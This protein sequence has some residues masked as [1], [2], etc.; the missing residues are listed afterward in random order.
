M[1]FDATISSQCSSGSGLYVGSECA[2]PVSLAAGR[3]KSE[4]AALW[5]VLAAK[6]EI[7]EFWVS[8]AKECSGPVVISVGRE[9][10][11]PSSTLAASNIVIS[12]AILA[13]SEIDAVH[14]VG[15]FAGSDITASWSVLTAN[16]SSSRQSVGVANDFNALQGVCVG[17]EAVAPH[18]LGSFAKAETKVVFDL[19]VA[20]E[21]I[22]SWAASA[23]GEMESH[24]G[25]RVAGDG[26]S[27]WAVTDAATI[28]SECESP[29]VIHVGQEAV[30]P[31]VLSG[32]PWSQCRALFGMEMAAEV[33]A[34]FGIRVHE[35]AWSSHI[36]RSTSEMS[37]PFA[38]TV[39]G[40]CRSLWS[41]RSYLAKAAVAPYAFSV[42]V[43]GECNVPFDLLAFNPVASHMSAIWCLLP[44]P[45]SEVGLWD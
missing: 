9:M 14:S 12:E 37:S 5:G 45:R 28:A 7:S 39:V 15:R 26:V 3:V 13:A 18:S 33:G 23:A 36:I 31:Y 11:A 38:C 42:P 30:V 17:S 40:Q 34:P 41:L 4:I 32:K 25:V 2:A 21:L 22:A 29:F 10:C 16:D 1:A 8:L 35:E 6:D 27:A 19:Q 44:A 43:Y 20:T 24:V